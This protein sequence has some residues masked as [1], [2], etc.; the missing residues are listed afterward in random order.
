MLWTLTTL[1]MMGRTTK[2]G[3]SAKNIAA[4]RNQIVK[5]MGMD[6]IPD[7]KHVSIFIALGCLFYQRIGYLFGG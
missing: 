6:H 4:I 1:L 2:A 7:I 3:N 5:D